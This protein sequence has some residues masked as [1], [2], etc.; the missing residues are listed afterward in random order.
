MRY[1]DIQWFSAQGC[2]VAAS[3]VTF[4]KCGSLKKFMAV[5]KFVAVSGRKVAE[6]VHKVLK[7]G[8]RKSFLKI[9]NQT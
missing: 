4:L 2:Q 5:P 7:C 1:T 9:P 6:K 3:T 8:R